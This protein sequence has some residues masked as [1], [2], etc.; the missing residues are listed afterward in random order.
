MGRG[1]KPAKSREAKAPVTRKAP[2]NDSAR[3]Q[4]LGKRLAEAQEQQAAT[5]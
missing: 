5:A 1:P 4:D 2:K 3:V